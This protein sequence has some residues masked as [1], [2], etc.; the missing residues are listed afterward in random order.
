MGPGRYNRRH[1]DE[2]DKEQHSLFVVNEEQLQQRLT[3]ATILTL[4]VDGGKFVVYTDVSGVSLGCVLI[5]DGKV[6]A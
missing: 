5:Q 1:N 3:T 2:V 4:P 6:V